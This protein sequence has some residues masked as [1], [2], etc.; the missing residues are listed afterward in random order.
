MSM[1]TKSDFDENLL[2]F[3]ST[4]PTRK[5]LFIGGRVLPGSTRNPLDA[6]HSAKSDVLS[7]DG[8]WAESTICT[9][10]RR[11]GDSRLNPGS[12]DKPGCCVII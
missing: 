3:T 7:G 1:E 10:T 8:D 6:V 9:W 12:H 5:N 4:V 11:L 2:V